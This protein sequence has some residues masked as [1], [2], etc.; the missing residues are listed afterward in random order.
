MSTDHDEAQTQPPSTSGGRRRSKPQTRDD[1]ISAAFTKLENQSLDGLTIREITAEVGLTPP[2]FYRHFADIDELS[3]ELID[4][5]VST[6]SRSLRSAT[7]NLTD[8]NVPAV[9]ATI[10]VSLKEMALREPATM[11][12]LA[13]ERFSGRPTVHRAVQDGLRLVT[14]ELASELRTRTH[15]SSWDWD[16]IHAIADAFVQ[17]GIRYMEQLLANTSTVDREQEITERFFKQIYV[18]S[19]GALALQP[20][21][22][23]DGR[24]PASEFDAVAWPD[25]PGAV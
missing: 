25:T 21:V 9:I 1:L 13:R 17:L 7:R 20:L 16:D 24:L 5:S 19:V 18:L 14:V 11:R 22:E 4:A 12:F 23:S 2:A 3:L 15:F 6:L 10:A 8:T